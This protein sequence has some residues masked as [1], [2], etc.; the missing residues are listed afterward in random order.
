MAKQH[1]K[2]DYYRLLTRPAATALAIGFI[3]LYHL[4]WMLGP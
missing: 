4:A 1:G 3:L 2:F